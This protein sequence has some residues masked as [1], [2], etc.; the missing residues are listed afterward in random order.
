MT[1]QRQTR[2]IPGAA[3]ATAATEDRAL[4][5]TKLFIPPP[6][7]DLVVRSR[8]H[9][10]LDLG[11]RRK[12]TLLAAPA[13]SGKTTLLGG[14][15]ATLTGA[16][17]PLAWVALDRGDNDPARF[18]RYLGAALDTLH[19]GTGRQ[20]SP[21]LDA[22]PPPLELVLTGAVNA[23]A[24]L[25]Q[26]VALVLDDYHSIETAALHAGIAFLLDHLPPRLHLVIA[27]RTDPPLALGRLR[28][29]DE[30]VEIRAAALRFTPDEASAFLT[31]AMA[32]PL[33]AGEVASLAERTEGWIAGLQ[34]AALSLRGL[35][36]ASSAAFI[37]AF[38]GSNR[39]VVDYLAEEVLER[40][41]PAMQDFLLHT[42]L[43][44][45]L[46]GPLCDAL[47]G[48][49]GTGQAT[50]EAL[51]RANLFVIPLDD[52]RRW[53]R[54]HQLFAGVLRQ[55]L[56]QAHPDLPPTLHRRASAWFRDHDLDGEAVQHA[57]AVPDFTE[58]AALLERSVPL[59]AFRGQLRT[60]L[61]WLDALPD[62]L[63]RA[64]P[65]LCI[66]HAAMLLFTGDLAGAEA[67][68]RD[69][70]RAVAP[71]PASDKAKTILGQVAA[72]RVDLA[73][74]VGDLPRGVALAE[75]ALALLPEIETTPLKLRAV[76][77]SDWSR[78]YLVTGDVTPASERLA[79]AAIPPVRANGNRFAALTSVTS[80]AR[81]HTLQGR[82]RQAAAT[83]ADA[84][85]MGT[86][87]GGLQILFGGPSYY[88]GL[89]ELLRERNDLAAA[90]YH[91]TQGMALVRTALAVDAY[92]VALGSIALARVHQARGIPDRAHAALD[93][94]AN[95]AQRR[96]FIAP[97][98]AAGSAARAELWLLQGDLT[99][100]SRWADTSGLHPDDPLD[101]PREPEYLALA[102]VRIA[103]ARD[104]ETDG[105]PRLDDT[106]CLL[107]QLL[108]AAK[109][110]ARTGSVIE[111]QILRSLALDARG[112]RTAALTSITHAVALAVPEGHRRV[113]L[114]AGAPLAALL[115]ALHA[116]PARDPLPRSDTRLPR[117]APRRL[118]C[119]CPG[120]CT[121]LRA[122]AAHANGTSA[123]AADRPRAGG[124]APDRRRS[125]ESGDCRAP[126]R[127]SRHGEVVRQ[128]HLR[129]IGRHQPHPG[130]RPRPHPAPPRRLASRLPMPPPDRAKPY[131]RPY[132]GAGVA[133]PA[134]PLCCA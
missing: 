1:R 65:I 10:L 88:L 89:G 68:L 121:G 114:D 117:D 100:A 74:F 92:Y 87:Q 94:F 38:A 110:G 2:P 5:A 104:A 28:V 103:Q 19:P 90:E 30:M 91:L 80:L 34:L 77:A 76:A 109:A 102:R 49:P 99:A 7:P 11:M 26:D 4:L 111:L 93:E 18:W 67:R 97:L 45:R 72:L 61:G 58:A 55:R 60:V 9:A 134:A 42:A 70:E 73:R 48:E 128:R 52:E 112:E 43:L 8:L 24:T 6:R 132:P 75:Q 125:G 107:D 124:A 106:L 129:Q 50:L 62:D 36:T 84:L 14:W 3:A 78:A 33:A 105:A 29:R 51:E 83:Y 101:Y 96:N 53:Y 119:R 126:L 120:S 118:R 32:L 71:H 41:P 123:R 85:A 130:R 40:Q 23:L 131:P 22:T 86:E 66:Y 64:R 16:A 20:L 35:G 113:F 95:L 98:H 46:S 82:L 79:L 37:D 13:G 56:H 115:A 133:L 69:A 12:L 59:A 39:F 127:D 15:R 25:P 108:S 47:T 57:L 122:T 21:L 81:L 27:S 116:T 17:I 31:E 54:Y 63:V 44:D